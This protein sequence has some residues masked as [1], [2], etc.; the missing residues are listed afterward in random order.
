MQCERCSHAIHKKHVEGVFF[1]VD[2]CDANA[3]ARDFQA[4][5]VAVWME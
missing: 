3:D 4:K 1:G 5:D 2:G